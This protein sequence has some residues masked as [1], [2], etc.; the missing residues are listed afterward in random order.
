MEY[1]IGINEFL[2]EGYGKGFVEKALQFIERVKDLFVNLKLSDIDLQNIADSSSINSAILMNKKFYNQVKD[3][4]NANEERIKK[5]YDLVFATN[6][7]CGTSIILSIA[8]MLA[9]YYASR[10]GWLDKLFRKFDKNYD[11]GG[12]TAGEWWKTSPKK[13]WKEKLFGGSKTSPRRR[14]EEPRQL[15]YRQDVKPKYVPKE[16]VKDKKE[17]MI[18]D[19]LDKM[20]KVGMDGLTPEE[21]SILKNN[22]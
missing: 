20:R 15:Q 6:E 9:F 1:L 17:L 14:I 4:V 21:K 12:D 3:I 19:I 5:E 8:V 22:K 2:N 18:D 10:K 7:G 11:S 16:I 13:S